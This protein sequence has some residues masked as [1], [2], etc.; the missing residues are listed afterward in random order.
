MPRGGSVVPPIV[1]RTEPEERSRGLACIVLVLVSF[2]RARGG[3]TTAG[4]G[5][6]VCECVMVCGGGAF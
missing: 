2:L 3:V 1:G 6:C 4:M 5:V